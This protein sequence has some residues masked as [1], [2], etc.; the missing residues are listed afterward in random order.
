[1]NTSDFSKHSII[2]LF[3]FMGI[4]SPCAALKKEI[5][6][7][8]PADLII[9]KEMRET[10]L[11]IG[12]EKISPKDSGF[13]ASLDSVASPFLFDQPEEEDSPDQPT[14]RVSLANYD[15]V[16]VLD[17]VSKIFANQVRGSMSR[18][19][20]TFL[21]LQG[22]TLVRP[23]TKFPATLPQA[24]NQ[25]FEITVLSIT[26][27]FYV[28]SLGDATVRMNYDRSESGS[29]RIQFTE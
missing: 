18:G 23:G 26:S 21:Q 25:R 27:E 12:E 3:V 14:A 10:V 20:M 19:D 6:L 28:L 9:K 11:Q 5:S 15:D 2:V 8:G 4:A 24:Q 1:M 13:I 17:A 7:S 29:G 22:G 16:S